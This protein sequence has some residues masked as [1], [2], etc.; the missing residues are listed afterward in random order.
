MTRWHLGLAGAALVLGA[1]TVWLA[2]CR[3]ADRILERRHTKSVKGVM[4]TVCLRCGKAEPLI[5][6]TSKEHRIAIKVGAIR[7]AKAR[8]GSKPATVVVMKR[9]AQ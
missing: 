4:H 3:H 2:R 8:A 1:L 6:R 9:R 5:D 7:K